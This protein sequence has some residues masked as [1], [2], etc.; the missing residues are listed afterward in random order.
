MDTIAQKG[1]TGKKP[2]HGARPHAAANV[3][4]LDTLVPRWRRPRFSR[5]QPKPALLFE[6]YPC[7]L[8]SIGFGRRHCRGICCAAAARNEKVVH[9]LLPRPCRGRHI[10]VV[11]GFDCLK[12][13]KH[14][15]MQILPRVDVRIFV[16]EGREPLAQ[17]L[18]CT[19]VGE[20]T[21]LHKGAVEEPVDGEALR[22]CSAGAGA[23]ILILGVRAAAAVPRRER[24]PP[25]QLAEQQHL[26]GVDLVLHAPRVGQEAELLGQPR[27]HLVV[28]HS[29]YSHSR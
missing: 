8:P 7:C 23:A 13:A 22:R 17:R 19:A 21:S 24:V 15:A 2:E 9:L 3:H 12:Q 14:L 18:P 29:S 6:V 16:G 20:R 1:H 10:F 5:F 11:R 25:V 26:G 27:A 28:Y 4:T